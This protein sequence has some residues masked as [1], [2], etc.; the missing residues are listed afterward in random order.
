MKN[1]LYYIYVYKNIFK[2]FILYYIYL[3]Q[4]ILVDIS[5]VKVQNYKSSTSKPKLKMKFITF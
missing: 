5:F 3:F 4:I 2:I 1:K